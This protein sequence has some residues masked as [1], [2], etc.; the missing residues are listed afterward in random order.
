MVLVLMSHGA[1]KAD[2]LSVAATPLAK[3]QM[4]PE[5]NALPQS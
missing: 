1:K 2:L 3:E 5:S 4:D